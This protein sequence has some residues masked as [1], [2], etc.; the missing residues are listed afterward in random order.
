M[1]CFNN[2]ARF[3]DKAKRR[4]RLVLNFHLKDQES[5]DNF[6]VFAGQEVLVPTRFIHF[7]NR[8]ALQKVLD[9]RRDDRYRDFKIRGNISRRHL[10]NEESFDGIEFKINE[11]SYDTFQLVMPKE[12]SLVKALPGIFQKGGFDRLRRLS[13]FFPDRKLDLDP[14]LIEIFRETQKLQESKENGQDQDL[15]EK[16]IALNQRL[17]NISSSSSISLNPETK[18][19][20]I[21]LDTSQ[22]KF[23]NEFPSEEE[24]KDLTWWYGDIEKPLFKEIN[25]K[26][27]LDRREKLQKGLK[28]EKDDS[29]ITRINSL[30]KRLEDR[31]TFEVE[32]IGK[33]QLFD[34]RLDARISFFNS[35]W[36]LSDGEEV[37]ELD[38]LYDLDLDEVNGFKVIKH[39]SE[40]ELVRSIFE[41]ARKRKAAFFIGHN[42][43]YDITQTTYAAEELKER[44]D[45]AV[46]GVKPRRD[47]V[48]YFYQ[49]MFQDFIYLDTLRTT[50][51]KAPFAKNSLTGETHKLEDVARYY[52]I[53]F[54]KSLNYEELR[55]LEIKAI[56]GKTREERIEAAREIARYATRDVD[57]LV[58]I[59]EKQ[60]FLTLLL[61]LKKLMPFC[62]L[63]QIA[64]SPRCAD[65]C[66]D[67]K[68]FDRNGN[69]RYFGYD[70]KEHEDRVQIFKKRFESL[71]DDLVSNFSLNGF[72]PGLNREVIQVYLPLEEHLREFL[73]SNFPDWRNLYEETKDTEYHFAFLQYLKALMREML[74]DYSFSR[75]ERE[76]FEDSV[77]R[78][79]LNLEKT[80]SEFEQ[81]DRLAR[82]E[83]KEE[84]SRYSSSYRYLKNQYRSIY[85]L[86][87]KEERRLVRHKRQKQVSNQLEF[88]FV[89]LMEED[90]RDLYL[91]RDKLENLIHLIPD[92]GSN[93]NRSKEDKE[94]GNEKSGKDFIKIYGLTK[95]QV[96]SLKR[97][98]SAF[99]T[100]EESSKILEEISTRANTQNISSRDFVYLHNQRR[101]A[102]HEEKRFLFSYY[103]NPR[104]LTEKIEEFY[105]EVAREISENNGTVLLRKGDYL[106]V[107]GTNSDNLKV[108]LPVRRFDELSIRKVK[109]KVESGSLFD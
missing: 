14:K 38:T 98:L 37:R 15:E 73:F 107:N 54:K 86:L 59:L 25:E 46:R 23:L 66:Y 89:S 52:G 4:N 41:R 67:K 10:N 102:N 22:I 28:K 39:D 93:D 18:E 96:G 57:P 43:P 91:L 30:I 53:D 69:H 49:R 40:K 33:V 100:L 78:K 95:K 34:P 48:R 35:I 16:V 31:L 50:Q 92:N 55:I 58:T 62:S 11:G 45:F 83:A 42:S 2:Y 60:K 61:K 94:S 8:G 19:Y 3:E 64:F 103:F 88:S 6:K 76:V 26:I 108:T 24:L 71:K 80:S 32:G 12:R 63:T 20:E 17:Q 21:S 13:G 99:K 29:R 109:E 27:L 81:F 101:A 82:E 36:K 68:H 75:R 97:Y 106:F 84:L 79:N 1:F 85:V 104:A 74:V 70:E 51:I 47:Y 7:E 65:A 90:N 9:L 56:L 105:R 77:R 5:V 44:P 87:E 72:S